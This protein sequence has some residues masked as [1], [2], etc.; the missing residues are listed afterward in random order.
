MGDP[1][2]IRVV[3]HAAVRLY[4]EGLGAL[5]DRAEGMESV[6]A[7]VDRAQ[8]IG[9]VRQ[10]R[11]HVAVVEAA[12]ASG[13]NAIRAVVTV[14]P[15]V[16]VV[17]IALPDSES[18]IIACAEAGI[19]GFVAEEAASD[20]LLLAVRS[21]MRGELVCSPRIARC[22]MRRVG[23]LASIGPSVEM[24]P[25]LTAREL[26]IVERIDRGLSNKEIAAQLHIEVST[27]KNH[28]HNLLQKLQVSR[29]GEA[30]AR[31]RPFLGQATPTRRV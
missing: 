31:L 7:T 22:L 16:Q 26:E 17:A 9:L 3:V 27:V 15:R 21:A 11:P 4:A 23:T 5:V 18:D 28:V 25:D 13:R 24:P 20:Q 19:A 10:K 2:P 30:A 1:S 12:S 14:D 6:G 29:R 8:L